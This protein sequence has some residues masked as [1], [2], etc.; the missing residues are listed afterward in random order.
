[1]DFFTPVVD[2]PYIF[3]QIAAANALSD[4][5]AMGGTPITA[6]NI[7]AFPLNTLPASVLAEILRGGAEKIK[8]AGAVLLGGHSIQ[9][10]EPKYGLSVTGVAHPTKIWTNA[11]ARPG[12]ALILTKPLGIGLITSAL[13]KKKDREGNLILQSPVSPELEQAAIDVMTK[14]NDKAARAGR[15]VG[16]SACTDITGFGLLGH[17]WEMAKA[18]QVKIEIDLHAVPVLSGAKELGL[19]GYIAGGN[20]ANLKYMEDKA[21]YFP[22]IEP[23]DK[24]VLADPITSGGLLL[25]VAEERAGELLNLLH[26]SGVAEARIIGRVLSGEPKIIVVP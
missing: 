23:I 10:A 7:I 21:E 17:A 24:N 25:S 5:Y 1:M 11:G 3:G 15:Q 12:D 6:L 14:L 20:W 2:D 9:D 22:E 26:E 19:K 18:S 8:E 13:R 16:V 4:I